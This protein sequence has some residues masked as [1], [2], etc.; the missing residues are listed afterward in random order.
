MPKWDIRL[1]GRCW[2]RGEF[3][4][5]WSQMPEKFEIYDGKMFGSEEERLHLLGALL[6]HVGVEK[7]VQLGDPDTWR[8]AVSKLR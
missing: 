7:A 4:E 6:E 8:A 1:H 2:E 3:D 5:R